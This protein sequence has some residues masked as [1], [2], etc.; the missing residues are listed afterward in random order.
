MPEERPVVL[1]NATAA[2]IDDLRGFR[3]VFRNI[4]GFN[5]HP[6]KIIKALNN[7]P[8]ISSS[9]KRDISIFTN[10]MD[11]LIGIRG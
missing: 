6:D 9:V 10:K 2:L 1:D 3:H 8:E 11:C 4:Y 7:L 5:I